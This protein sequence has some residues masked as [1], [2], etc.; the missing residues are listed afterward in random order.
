MLNVRAGLPEKSAAQYC[1]KS[2]V[3][4]FHTG[5]FALRIHVGVPDA[6]TSEEPET[7]QLKRGAML[8]VNISQCEQAGDAERLTECD[9]VRSI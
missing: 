4:L 1:I 9:C 8:S 2:A 5:S 7:L 3:G 6:P